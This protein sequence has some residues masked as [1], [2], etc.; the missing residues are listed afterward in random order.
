ML[1]EIERAARHS[2]RKANGARMACYVEFAMTTIAVGLLD[3]DPAIEKGSRMSAASVERIVEQSSRRIDA[4]EWPVAAD[5]D[6]Q[7][8]GIRR[9][10]WA[11]TRP[12]GHGMGRR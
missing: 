4:A 7:P 1:N 2:R 11:R 10:D 3:A 6:P 9:G 5:L 8:A 12:Y